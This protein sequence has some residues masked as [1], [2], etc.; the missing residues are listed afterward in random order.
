MKLST[1]V[2]NVKNDHVLKLPVPR[3]SYET[4]VPTKVAERGLLKEEPASMPKRK[5]T[6]ELGARYAEEHHPVG[7]FQ[8]T[9]EMTPSV[10]REEAL[11]LA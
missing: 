5:A 11:L 9:G 3:K 2:K 7:P 10:L 8:N 1:A 6:L 4:A